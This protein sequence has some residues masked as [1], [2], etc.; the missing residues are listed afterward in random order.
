MG[1]P[2]V[3][4]KGKGV[5]AERLI[6]LARENGIPVVED[7]LLVE[8]LERL[9]LDREIPAE[10]YQVVAEILVA[11]YKSEKSGSKRSV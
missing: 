3:T 4:A 10:L 5:V 9:D 2:K 11:V 7:R 8:T 6:A 1:A